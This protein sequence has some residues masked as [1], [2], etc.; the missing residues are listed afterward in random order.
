MVQTKK[1]AVEVNGNHYV[2]F[3][4]PELNKSEPH[5]L[6]YTI[7]KDRGFAQAVH[8][9]APDAKKSL[10]TLGRSHETDIKLNDSS[11][12]RFHASIIYTPGKG[13]I[14]EDNTSKFGT[15]VLLKGKHEVEKSMSVQVDKS[16]LTFWVKERHE[17]STK[18]LVKNEESPKEIITV[19]GGTV[20]RKGTTSDS[21][22][23][24]SVENVAAEENKCGKVVPDENQYTGKKTM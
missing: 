13:F 3:D 24:V 17:K 6:L 15:L 5:L 20:E 9:L 22:V 23:M 14:L 8:I 11:V 7:N 12:S 19:T 21:N 10:F 1:V 16:I 4:Q 2:L 18:S